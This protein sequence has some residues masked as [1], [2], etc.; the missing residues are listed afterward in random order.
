MLQQGVRARASVE[1]RV[2][3]KGHVKGLS[4][5]NASL[6]TARKRT[7]DLVEKNAHRCN[8]TSYSTSGNILLSPFTID[9]ALGNYCTQES[10]ALWQ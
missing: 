3:V 4:R 1:L 5:A 9:K 2:K 7:K 10:H 8:R 6:Y